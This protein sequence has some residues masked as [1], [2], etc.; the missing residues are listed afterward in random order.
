[1][2]PAPFGYALADGRA[3][4]L[5]ILAREGDEARPLAGGQSLVPMMN[6]RIARP[7]FLVDLNRCA[8]LCFVRKD[9]SYLRIGAMTRQRTIEIDPVVQQYCPLVATALA[10][11][12]S[13][14]IRNRGTIGGSIANGY[15]LADL[16]PVALVLDAKMNVA[17]PAG[18][19][20]ILAEGF[21]VDGMVTAVEPGEL[22]VDI[23]FATRSAKSCFS[24]RKL[25]NHSS[26]GAIIIVAASAEGA[27]DG[28]LTAVRFAVAGVSEK[29]IRFRHVEQAVREGMSER[30]IADAV[31]ADLAERTVAEAS[32][33]TAYAHDV[34]VTLVQNALAELTAA[35]LSGGQDL[36]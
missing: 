2:K 13:I 34:A 27:L 7:S 36:Q 26:G 29:A 23:A 8:D 20:N 19:K 24:F 15:P 10:G 33:R 25:G 4:A 5:E 17:G 21:F 11:A 35:A 31:R 22:L 12:G 18:E 1:M 6:F 16:I 28:R 30:F 14:A 32:E 3:H 9:E